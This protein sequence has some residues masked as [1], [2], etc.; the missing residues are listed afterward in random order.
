MHPRRLQKCPPQPSTRQLTFTPLRTVVSAFTDTDVG[1]D[2]VSVYCAESDRLHL[3]CSGGALEDPLCF[4]A[5]RRFSGLI[6]GV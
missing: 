3:C 6:A 5:W 2:D 4:S 1:L